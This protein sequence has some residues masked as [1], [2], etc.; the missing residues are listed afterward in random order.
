LERLGE[1]TDLVHEAARCDRRVVRE[2]LVADVYELE[3]GASDDNDGFGVPRL[4]AGSA[5]GS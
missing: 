1:T 2:R 3:H 5:R 4:R